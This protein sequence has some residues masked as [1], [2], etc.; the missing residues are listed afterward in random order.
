MSGIGDWLN[1]KIASVTGK[2]L[3]QH[4]DTVKGALALP[5]ALATDSGSAKMLGAPSQPAGTTMAGG[6]RH[7]KQKTRKGGKR[8][9]GTRRH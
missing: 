2:T 8:H 1:S 6:R 7:R 9:R 5:P 3:Q 4:A